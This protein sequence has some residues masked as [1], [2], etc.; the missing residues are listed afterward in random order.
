MTFHIHLHPGKD[1]P[2]QVHFHGTDSAALSQILT[3]LTALRKESQQDM[4]ALDDK[5]TALTAEVA[6]NTTVEKSALTLI[7]GF[8]ATLA[9]AIAA[10]QAAG[11]SPAQLQSLTD[12]GTAL[13]SN[14]DELAAAVLANTPPPPPSTP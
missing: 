13:K 4:S 9:A 3:L 8:A 7:Q 1:G 10:A 14:D 12:L 11:A 6:S 2:A 5:I